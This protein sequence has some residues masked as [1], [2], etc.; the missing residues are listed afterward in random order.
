MET[1]TQL[2]RLSVS[3]KEA[4]EKTPVYFIVTTQI[5]DVNN[6]KQ[7]DEYILKV[8][9]IVESYGGKYIVRSEQITAMWDSRKPDRV[10]IIQFPSKEQIY[11]WLSA[12]E[13]KE[14][15]NLRLESVK[16][17]AIIVE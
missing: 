2:Q 15:V 7:Y 10:N 17:E 5:P 9:P 13:Y 4:K 16:T 11:K 8:K 12:P 14:I 6:R 3:I 1:N